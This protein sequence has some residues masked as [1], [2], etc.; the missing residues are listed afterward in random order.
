MSVGLR[1]RT[2]YKPVLIIAL[3]LTGVGLLFF[4]TSFLLNIKFPMDLPAVFVIP[5]PYSSLWFPVVDGVSLDG[6]TIKALGLAAVGTSLGLLLARR[7]VRV[8][9]LVF[10]AFVFWHLKFMVE[11]HP[12]DHELIRPYIFLALL[13]A[14]AT[15]LSLRAP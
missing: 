4:Q 14:L 15:M 2:R 8:L 6:E 12:R 9:S 13:L 7:Y 5:P 10:S 3:I 1:A 11:V